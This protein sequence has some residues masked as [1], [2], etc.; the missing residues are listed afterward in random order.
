MYRLE[1]DEVADALDL[2]R[3]VVA[4][5]LAAAVAEAREAMT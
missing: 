5:A 1:L 2:P 3:E 4:S